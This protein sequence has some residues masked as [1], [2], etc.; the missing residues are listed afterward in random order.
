[1]LVAASALSAPAAVADSA[2]IQSLAAI[3]ST[4]ATFV[5]QVHQDDTSLTVSVRTLDQRLRLPACESPL[6]AQWSPGSRDT[7]QVTVRVAC[8]SAKPWQLHVQANVSREATVWVL[9]RAA[10]RNAV[11]DAS[12]VKS[13]TVT[14]G[15][16]LTTASRSGTP[17]SELQAWLGFAFRQSAQPGQL[18]TQRM[19]VPQTLV[20]RGDSVRIRDHR[21]G[22]Q[23]EMAG[24]ALGNGSLDQRIQIKNPASGKVIDATVI[25]RGVVNPIN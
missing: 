19:L 4:V 11:L 15:R 21:A 22:L 16:G 12:M 9:T 23:V 24:T 3:Q 14:L 17:V 2:A 13:Q 10:E 5:R 20:S 7:G 25:A 8:Q 1:M 18:L 6:D